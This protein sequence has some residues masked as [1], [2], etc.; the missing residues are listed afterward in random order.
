MLHFYYI[1]V[2]QTLPVSVIPIVDGENVLFQVII[3][4][5]IYQL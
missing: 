4:V 2:P 3:N 5:S 1:S